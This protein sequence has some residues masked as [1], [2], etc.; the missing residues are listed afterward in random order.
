VRTRGFQQQANL[1]FKLLFA[2]GIPVFIWLTLMGQ[3][4]ISGLLGPKWLPA[5]PLVGILALARAL[6]LP[7]A[8]TEP[9]LSLN[10]EIGRL[11][12]F[13]LTLLVLT[14]A[15]T[16]AGAATGLTAVAWSQVLAALI[17][18]VA[19][20]RMLRKHGGIDWREVLMDAG[21]LVPP[22]LLGSVVIL[23][24]RELPVFQSL[25]ALVRAFGVVIPATAIYLLA[26]TATEPAVR[27][28]TLSVIRRRIRA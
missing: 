2:L 26:L 17:A 25:P 11:P 10:G 20:N 23:L 27:D 5:L 24:A 21:R 16:A 8:A 19:T 18:A 4:L 14:V 28:I 13:N 3:D 7:A 9:I 6:S 22:V 12:L 1:Y 15:L